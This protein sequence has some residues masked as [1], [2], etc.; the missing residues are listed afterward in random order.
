MTWTQLWFLALLFLSLLFCRR[1]RRSRRLEQ[2]QEERQ[3]MI[4]S[5]ENELRR[6]QGLCTFQPVPVEWITNPIA[7]T[8]TRKGSKWN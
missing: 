2:E 4:W 6:Q 7:R 1:L 3:A 8:K 5:V